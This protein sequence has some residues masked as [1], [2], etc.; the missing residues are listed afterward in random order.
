[1]RKADRKQTYSTRLKILSKAGFPTYEEFL[2][3]EVWRAMRIN[4]TEKYRNA[5]ACCFCNL[6]SHVILHH[7]FYGKNNIQKGKMKGILP[8]CD[9][10]HLGIHTIEKLYNIDPYRATQIFKIIY[11]PNN[12]NF[13]WEEKSKPRKEERL[14]NMRLVPKSGLPETLHHSIHA[15]L[16]SWYSLS[17][18]EFLVK[19]EKKKSKDLTMQKIYFDN[20]TK[21]VDYLKR[22]LK[23]NTN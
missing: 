12:P 2:K 10:C 21:V 17:L 19:Y 11:Y 23:R 20:K 15:C 16:G 3:S 1:M 9:I 6:D 22:I 7:A 18:E 13:T 8:V 5:S 4:R 14:L